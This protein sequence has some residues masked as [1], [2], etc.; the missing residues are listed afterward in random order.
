VS[1]NRRDEYVM[2]KLLYFLERF[3]PAQ[4]LDFLQRAVIEVAK[5]PGGLDVA[6]QVVDPQPAGTRQP[7]LPAPATRRRI[8]RRS[9]S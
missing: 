5:L 1:R 7:A 4:R 3:S 6:A 9:R 2:Q 8:G